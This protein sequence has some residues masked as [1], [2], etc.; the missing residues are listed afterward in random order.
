MCSFV[1]YFE[2]DYELAPGRAISGN[3]SE[4]GAWI[5]SQTDWSISQGCPWNSSSCPRL[6]LSFLSTTE[7]HSHATGLMYKSHSMWPLRCSWHRERLSNMYVP[8]WEV[9]RLII[10]GTSPGSLG[11]LAMR[12]IEAG[13][14]ETEIGQKAQWGRGEESPWWGTKGCSGE[15]RIFTSKSQEARSL[16]NAMYFNSLNLNPNK[17]YAW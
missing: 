9:G 3:H 5:W 15:R 6:S 1:S 12:S 4:G 16:E 13:F 7:N 11:R 2:E 17:Y 10:V 14:E 8:P